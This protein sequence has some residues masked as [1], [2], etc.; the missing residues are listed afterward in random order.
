MV[1]EKWPLNDSSM[2]AAWTRGISVAVASHA[3]AKCS[4]VKGPCALRWPSSA[5]SSSSGMMGSGAWAYDP[6]PMPCQ[7]WR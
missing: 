1:N 5:R 2:P 4:S 6:M 3:S 7:R